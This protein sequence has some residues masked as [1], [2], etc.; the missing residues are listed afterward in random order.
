MNG[1]QKKILERALE[2]HNYHNTSSYE[3]EFARNLLEKYED[4][5]LTPAQNKII[6]QLSSKVKSFGK[7]KP[8]EDADLYE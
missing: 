7:R 4:I 2:P 5:E 3:R 1:F 8:P 6:N